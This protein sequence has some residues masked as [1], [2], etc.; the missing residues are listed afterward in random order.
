MPADTICPHRLLSIFQ[1]RLIY[2]GPALLRVPWELFASLCQESIRRVISIQEGRAAGVNV[3]QIR[4]QRE[5][6]G[7]RVLCDDEDR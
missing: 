3:R 6:E 1:Q 5:R 7:G 2:G 4:R